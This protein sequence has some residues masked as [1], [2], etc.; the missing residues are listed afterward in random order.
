MADDY[1]YRSQDI[2]KKQPWPSALGSESNYNLSGLTG[3]SRSAGFSSGSGANTGSPSVG[4][5]NSSASGGFSLPAGVAGDILYHNGSTWVTLNQQNG[6]LIMKDATP[7]WIVNP[8]SETH[9]L[10]S[11]DGVVQWIETTDCGD[12]GP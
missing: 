8:E 10:G 2:S 3:A 12:T 11:I 5:N 7:S 4:N 1:S 6:V 9:V